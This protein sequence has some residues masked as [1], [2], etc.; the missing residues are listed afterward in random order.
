MTTSCSYAAYLRCLL[1]HPLKTRI[2][3][4]LAVLIIARYQYQ[5]A[6]VADQ[7]INLLACLTEIMV[8]VWPSNDWCK[9]Y[10]YRDWWRNHQN[11]GITSGGENDY[12]CKKWSLVVNFP[13]WNWCI[14][15]AAMGKYA[16]NF[17][18]R[19]DGVTSPTTTWRILIVAVQDDVSQEI[20]WNAWAADE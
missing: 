10:P 13:C 4:L 9:T 14:D 16:L 11:V 1:L 7:E 5:I 8:R 15:V 3:F 20:W 17:L 19:S 18:I 6:F 2:A 12:Y